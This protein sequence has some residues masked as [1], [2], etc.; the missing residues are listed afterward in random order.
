MDGA[1]L[2]DLMR[3]VSVPVRVEYAHDR[4]RVHGAHGRHEG[5]DTVRLARTARRVGDANAVAIWR[6]RAHSV[7]T[8]HDSTLMG[9]V[10]R[11]VEVIGGRDHARRVPT[12]PLPAR[13]PDQLQAVSSVVFHIYLHTGCGGSST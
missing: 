9:I 1:P 10:P 8:L 7:E 12:L 13:K 11:R 6:I 4:R 2:D 3:G 5:R